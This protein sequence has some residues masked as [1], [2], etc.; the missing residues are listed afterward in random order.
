MVPQKGATPEMIE[1]LDKNLAH[2]AH[3]IK[4]SIGADVIDRPGAGAGGGIGA[5]LMAFTNSTLKRGVELVVAATRLEDHMQGAA[6]AF[7]G[8]GRVDVADCLRQ[9]PIRRRHG[10]AQARRA[11][12]RHRRR[13]RR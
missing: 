4:R 13:P 12:R 6:L 5:G 9:D 3:V 10:G 11:G 7:T 1:R 8:E 2:F